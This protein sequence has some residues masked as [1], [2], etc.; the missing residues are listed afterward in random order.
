MDEEINGFTE[1][2]TAEITTQQES[3]AE[4]PSDFGG[5]LLYGLKISAVGLSVVFI[6]LIIL[7]AI[8][9]LFE[10]FM[11]TIPNKR[12]QP[13]VKKKIEPEKNIIDNSED[14]AEIAAVIAAAVDA[15]YANDPAQA[16]KHY[17]VK[18][19]KRI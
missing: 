10:L 3:V 16:K 19:F 8:I 7:M 1:D 13:E 9:K 2:L 5:R 18:S 17:R 6:V 12:K 4:V 14:D 11:Y 15:Y